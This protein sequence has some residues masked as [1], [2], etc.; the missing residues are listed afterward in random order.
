MLNNWLFLSMRPELDI[1][2]MTMQALKTS[3]SPYFCYNCV[4]SVIL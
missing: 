2:N 3:I 4:K 1:N